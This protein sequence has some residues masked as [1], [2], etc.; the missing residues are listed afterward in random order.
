MKI[1]PTK[2]NGECALSGVPLEPA[3]WLMDAD[4]VI[5]RARGGSYSSENIRYVDPQAHMRRHGILRERS[6][7]LDELKAVFDDRQQMIRL[8][9]KID[10]Q[11]RAYE[12]RTDS[13]R[14]ATQTALEAVKAPVEERIER[15]TA[16][17]TKLV[18]NL[19]KSDR[20]VDAALK[21]KGLGP[22]TAAA[23]TLYIDLTK[24]STP[25]ALWKYC[26]LHAPSH[27]RYRKG[28]TSGGNKTLRT[29]LYTTAESMMKL[30]APGYREIYD[31]VKTRLE[32]SAKVTMTRNGDGKLTECEWRN[33]KACHRHGAA[34]RALIKQLLADYWTTG[35]TLLC[36][37]LTTPYVQ[38]VLGHNDIVPASER[39][40]KI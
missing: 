26:G 24:A 31:R 16:E 18:K 7:E 10:N 3:R 8:R 2:H 40:W 22:V 32:A 29:V 37:P 35:R 27:E 25:S 5:P 4:H 12:R 28:E 20:L 38:G 36:L 21:V 33:T 11:F 34:L 15:V 17:L 9:N 30:R 39:G 19:A 23:L 1:K 13:M 14:P 6:R